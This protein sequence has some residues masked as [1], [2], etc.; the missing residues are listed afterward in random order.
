MELPNNENELM[1]IISQVQEKLNKIHEEKTIKIGKE[2]LIKLKERF[3]E[4]KSR[5]FKV[6]TE[7]E[8]TLRSYLRYNLNYPHGKYDIKTCD[9][10]SVDEIEPDFLYD[11]VDELKE[12][13]YYHLKDGLKEEYEAYKKEIEDFKKEINDLAKEHDLKMKTIMEFLLDKEPAMTYISMLVKQPKITL[14]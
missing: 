7:V 12:D 5:D 8:I 11:D 3:N 14:E 9:F 2:K 13:S 1:A 4:L 6:K 10:L